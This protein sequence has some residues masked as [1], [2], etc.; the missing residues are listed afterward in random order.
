MSGPEVEG[1]APLGEIQGAVVNACHARPMA[2]DM[3]EHGL[4]NMRQ[5]PISPILVAIVLRIS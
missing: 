2:A 3:V 5:H 4:Y 1:L